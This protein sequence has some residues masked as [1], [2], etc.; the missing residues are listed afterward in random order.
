MLMIF[1]EFFT[2][3]EL[4]PRCCLCFCCRPD[5]QTETELCPGVE[6][7]P[8]VT[9]KT[10]TSIPVTDSSVPAISAATADVLVSPNIN[11]PATISV[12]DS[13][14]PATSAVTVDVLVSSNINTPA[15][16]P[17]TDSSVPATSA[18]TAITIPDNAVAA[19]SAD[20][21]APPNFWRQLAR[22]VVSPRGVVAVIIMTL[23]LTIPI[24]VQVI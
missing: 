15:I 22:L 12:T 10:T 24:G 21:L 18:A 19:I 2:N 17:V 3:F 14:V 1:P 23:A 20:T 4:I 16:I 9:A 13:S 8:T 5:N 11:T 6:L 7:E